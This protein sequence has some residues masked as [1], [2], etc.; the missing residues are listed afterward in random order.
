MAE[1]IDMEDAVEQK[2]SKASVII[3]LVLVTAIAA[4]MGF[5]SA[6]FLAPPKAAAEK[7]DTGDDSSEDAAKAANVV[8]TDLAPLLT[9]IQSP[10]GV[11][12]RLEVSLMSKEPV[13]ASLSTA[14]G[15]DLV[16]YLRTLRLS[17]IEGPSG[18]ITFREALNDRATH[19]SEGAVD[20]VLIRTLLFE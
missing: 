3:A 5:G 8:L 10:E 20:R 6:Q 15:E 16:A 19:F 2:S 11:W 13:A 1:T 18:F 4:G 9:N 14:V 12:V 17:H 7:S